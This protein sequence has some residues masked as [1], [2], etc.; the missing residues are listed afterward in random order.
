MNIRTHFLGLAVATLVTVASVSASAQQ[1]DTTSGPPASVTCLATN[2]KGHVFAGT[3]NSKV[4]KT[5]DKGETWVPF[6]QGI[7]DGGPD[8]YVISDIKNGAGDDLYACVRGR[9]LFKSTDDG[10]S[11]VDLKIPTVLRSSAR[12]S[13]STKVLPSGVTRI[14]VGVDGGTNQLEMFMSENDGQTWTDIPKSS[15]PG[16]ISSIFATFQS[17]NSD[18]I[19]TLVSYNKGLYR[20]NNLGQSWTRIDSDPESGESDDNF[21]LM[22]SDASGTLWLG[23]NSLPTSI[24]SKNACIM[25]ST[26]DGTSWKYKVTGWNNN[27]IINNRVTGIAFSTL[28]EIFATTEKSGT[29]YS[30]DGGE[31]WVA[32]NTGV[33]FGDGSAVDVV[34]TK[35]NDVFLAPLGEYV[36]KYNRN[37]SSVDD[38]F[39]VALHLPTTSPNPVSDVVHIG[40]GLDRATD[41]RVDVF[42]LA[43]SPVI[44]PFYSPAEA[45]R[46]RVTLD[47]STMTPGVYVWR[48]TAGTQSLTQRF[49][50]T[51]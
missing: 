12:V 22:T 40:F 44:A 6:D 5:T 2:S 8:F 48:V 20:S 42:D 9:G 25:K 33:Q 19:F 1:W 37:P 43:G 35:D 26:N 4:Y 30:S 24:H 28:N 11:W 32:W 17:P 39:N 15:L 50:V 14:F 27:N 29:F 3:A 31:N 18:L 21:N 34:V 7:E 47:V 51:H 23:R 49:V 13:V 41:V 36:Y 16:Q 45:G 10:E 46:S 38:V